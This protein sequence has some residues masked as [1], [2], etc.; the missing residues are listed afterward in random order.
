MMIGVHFSD[1]FQVS[2]EELEKYGAF[3]I[4][5]I[6]DV[7]LFIDPFLLFS[8]EKP[9]YQALHKQILDYLTFLNLP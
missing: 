5:L 7:P 8:S 2:S 6:A 9:E 4:S 3:D 1:I